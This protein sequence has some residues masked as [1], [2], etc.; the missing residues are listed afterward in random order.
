MDDTR[1]GTDGAKGR[2][3]VRSVVLGL[4][5]QKGGSAYRTTK[6]LMSI[7]YFSIMCMLS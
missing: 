5:W 3:F 1:R 2:E 4:A 7:V 6:G